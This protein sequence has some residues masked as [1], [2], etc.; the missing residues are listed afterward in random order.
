MYVFNA[1]AVWLKCHPSIFFPLGK[2]IIADPMRTLYNIIKMFYG[3]KC[4]NKMIIYNIL[5]IGVI[6]QKRLE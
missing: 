3:T 2:K 1:P 4:N 6:F 5:K